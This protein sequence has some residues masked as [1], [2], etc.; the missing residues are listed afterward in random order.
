MTEY[1]MTQNIQ[2]IHVSHTDTSTSQSRDHVIMSELEIAISHG[3]H[4]HVALLSTPQPIIP[5]RSLS[6]EKKQKKKKKWSPPDPLLR[7][8][9][10]TSD[11]SAVCFRTVSYLSLLLCHISIL[12]FLCLFPSCLVWF[13]LARRCFFAIATVT[14]DRRNACLARSRAHSRVHENENRAAAF[15]GRKGEPPHI[16]AIDSWTERKSRRETSGRRWIS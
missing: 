16:F 2:I 8:Y 3:T 5:R 10:P 13:G 7:Y 12:E 14:R 15:N 9:H 4:I 11:L 6:R 1:T